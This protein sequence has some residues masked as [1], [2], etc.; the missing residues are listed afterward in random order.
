MSFETQMAIVEVVLS[1]SNPKDCKAKPG[2]PGK[3]EV[4]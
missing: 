3:W 4:G 2:T 1:N